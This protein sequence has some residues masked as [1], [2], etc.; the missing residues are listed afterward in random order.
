[1]EKEKQ[2]VRPIYHKLLI[3]ALVIYIVGSCILVTEL[4]IKVGKI[5]HFLVHR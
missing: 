1:M 2:C 5:E 3:A 4:Y